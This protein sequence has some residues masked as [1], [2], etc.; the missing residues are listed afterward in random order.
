MFGTFGE[1]LNGAVLP[2]FLTVC[3]TVLA[4]R[5]K[6]FRILSPAGFFCDLRSAWTG[7]GTSPF[8]SLC[9][10]LAGT[11]GVGNIAGVATAIGSGGAGA[12]F[13][14]WAGAI[15]STAVKYGEVTLAVKY[16]R[17]LKDGYYGGAAYTIRDGMSCMIGPG[18]SKLL[19]GLFAVLCVVNS[20]VMGT[21]IQS[22]SA[23]AVTDDGRV[24]T[25]ICLLLAA[26]VAAVAVC[27]PGKIGKVTPALIPPLSLVY[28]GISVYVIASNVSLLPAVFREIFSGAFRFRAAAG[29]AAGFGIK[30]AIRYGVTRGI[31]SNEAGC[32]TSPTAHAA[33]NVES[34]HKQGC[35]GIF[36][37]V[38]DTLVLCTMTALVVL[39]GQLKYGITGD[40]GVDDTLFAFGKLSGTPAYLI[41]GISVI[42]FAYATVTSQLYYGRIALGYLTRSRFAGTAFGIA[43]VAVTA[44]GGFVDTGVAW[45]VA[46]IVVGLM[47]VIN[48]AVLIALSEK[49][50][51]E[52]EH[53]LETRQKKRTRG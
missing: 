47:T 43:V 51:Q 1:V 5:I 2:F 33:A 30:E 17:R 20:L 46:D 41:I 8:V 38:F 53:G 10:A 49:V 16:R 4:F 40:A 39:I 28:I 32:G 48:V 44:I 42:L 27:G 13:W 35:F 21:L 25:I 29:G 12:V 52:A 15:V 3:G 31:F 26:G 11:L 45:S 6:L 24:R 18:A 7:S 22:N 34:P 19:G 14:M 23:A 36:E 37:V 9:T 50:G